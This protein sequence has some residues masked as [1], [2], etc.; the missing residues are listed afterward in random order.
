MEAALH[1]VLLLIT[2]FIATND[3]GLLCDKNLCIISPENQEGVPMTTQLD[4]SVAKLRKQIAARVD[5]IKTDLAASIERNTDLND[6]AE[7]SIALLEMALDRYIDLHGEQDARHLIDSS[8]R[9]AA[10]KWKAGL[11]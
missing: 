4:A 11:N 2:D 9:R 3:K 6:G 7:V 8:F 1:V 10:Q 5:E